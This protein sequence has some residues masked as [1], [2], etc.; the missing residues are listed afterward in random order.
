MRPPRKSP[1]LRIHGRSVRF[2]PPAFTESLIG[3]WALLIALP[4]VLGFA[5]GGP[6]TYVPVAL[7]AI[8]LLG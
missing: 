6:E 3:S 4:W 2:V 7:G 8:G 5:R 1:H